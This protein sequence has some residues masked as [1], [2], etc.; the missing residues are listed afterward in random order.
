MTDSR[1]WYLRTEDEFF[2]LYSP[3]EVGK[4]GGGDFMRDHAQVKDEPV[5]NVWSIVVSDSGEGLW[6]SP[7]FR[8]V[9]VIGYVLTEKPWAEGAA[10]E[11][12]L[13]GVEKALDQLADGVDDE[14]YAEQLADEV[15]DRL[16]TIRF[17]IATRAGEQTERAIGEWMDAN[18]EDA[19][20]VK[21]RDL[22]QRLE[23]VL[24]EAPTPAR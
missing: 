24:S 21:L 8:V 13:D 18:P 20:T 23:E 3:V 1:P 6:A 2:D 16:Y 17:E 14:D 4:E 5:N 12:W 10:D 9:N 19:H 11:V 15:R 22:T 7:G